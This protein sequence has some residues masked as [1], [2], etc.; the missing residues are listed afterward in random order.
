MTRTMVAKAAVATAV[1]PQV[2]IV[3]SE[4][5]KVKEALQMLYVEIQNLLV[6]YTVALAKQCITRKNTSN[7]KFKSKKHATLAPDSVQSILNEKERLIGI[8]Q[9]IGKTKKNSKHT[10][11]RE[12]L[13]E[14]RKSLRHEEQLSLEHNVKKTRAECAKLRKCSVIIAKDAIS[15][16][17]GT[18]IV[19]ILD[20]IVEEAALIQKREELWDRYQTLKAFLAKLISLHQRATQIL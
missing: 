2:T 8:L 3:S 17:E 6:A 14:I 7:Q 18:P 15:T 19:T 10:I 16:F 1:D 9:E 12:N 5:Q 4:S 13:A 11:L 20:S